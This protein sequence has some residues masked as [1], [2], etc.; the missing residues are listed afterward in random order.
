[1]YSMYAEANRWKTEMIDQNPTELG[2]FK[3]VVFQVSG[4]MVYSKLKFESGVHRVQR[5]PETEA[6]GRIHT[7]TVTVAVLPE[8]EE[9]DLEINPTD[10]RIDVYR[11]SGAADSMSTKRNQQ[12][13]SHICPQELWWRASRSVHSCKTRNLP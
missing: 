13:V 4:N 7:S 2:G 9:V 10:L 12:C 11:A 8:A 3:E 1:M 6:G 5:V